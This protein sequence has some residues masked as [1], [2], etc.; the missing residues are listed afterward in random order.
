[1]N[2]TV[3]TLGIVVILIFV[4]LS[5]CEESKEDDSTASKSIP[6]TVE[7]IAQV[8]NKSGEPVENVSVSFSVGLDGDYYTTIVRI[9]DSTGW[10]PFAVSSFSLPLNG[11]GALTVGITG[12]FTMEL[13]SLDYKHANANKVNN[14]YYWSISCRLVQ[15]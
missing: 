3:L 1:M 11:E 14:A 15:D 6:V 13:Y 4:S 5:G 10:T 7:A 8:V 12:T 2:K 9:T